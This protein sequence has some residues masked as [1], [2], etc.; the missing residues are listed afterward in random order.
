FELDERGDILLRL[1]RL[2]HSTGKLVKTLIRGERLSG[3]VGIMIVT[4][5]FSSPFPSL[6]QLKAGD[7]RKRVKPSVGRIIRV[8]AKS[9][10]TSRAILSN[11]PGV[12]SSQVYHQKKQIDNRVRANTGPVP[13]IDWQEVLRMQSE[14]D[15]VCSHRSQ[16]GEELYIFQSSLMRE[17]FIQSLVDYDELVKMK[18]KMDAL[19]STGSIDDINAIDHGSYEGVMEVDVTFSVAEGYFVIIV[20][21]FS[22]DIKTRESMKKALVPVVLCLSRKHTLETFRIIGE[23]IDRLLRIED[24]ERLRARCLMS[25][26]EG[27]F[28]GL[29]EANFARDAIK[30]DCSIHL[31]TNLENATEK[32]TKNESMDIKKFLLGSNDGNTKQLV[33]GALNTLNHSLFI[34][35]V[36]KSSEL[37][38]KGR[39]WVSKRRKNLWERMG[40]PARLRGG[41]GWNL[42]TMFRMSGKRAIQPKVVRSISC[43]ARV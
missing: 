9:G 14:D 43:S 11:V 13:A 39:K 41:V 20:S 6:S 28:R 31:R 38:D 35:E 2:R 29:L 42:P 30:L 36:E 33:G 27:S 37:T 23:N 32:F 18:Q 34:R 4:Y 16:G 22:K 40:L 19:I 10:A 7:G 3:T 12:S 26:K 1:T 17:N 8:L 5:T 24:K 25:D 21:I 15:V